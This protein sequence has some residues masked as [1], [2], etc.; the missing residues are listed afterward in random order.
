MN[1]HGREDP[2]SDKIGEIDDFSCFFNRKRTN[3]Q[4]AAAL[5]LTSSNENIVGVAAHYAVHTTEDTVDVIGLSETNQ[6]NALTLRA[7]AHLRC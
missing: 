3:K 2:H 7:P 6:I 4:T 5:S 1:S